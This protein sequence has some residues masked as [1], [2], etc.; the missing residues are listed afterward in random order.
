MS[1]SRLTGRVKWFN[2]KSGF[3]FLTV[4]GES[5]YKDKDIF[6]HYSSISGEDSQYKYLVQ[7][8]YVEFDLVSS[9]GEKHEFQASNVGGVLAGP[10]MCE[11]HR[12]NPRPS[13]RNRDDDGDGDGDRSNRRPP[14]SRRQ[15]LESYDSQEA[16]VATIGKTSRARVSKRY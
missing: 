3:G 1:D 8:E 12:D 4:C 5:D 16:S 14:H 11:T 10:T 15:H 2:K 13:P 6:A 9:E 7:G